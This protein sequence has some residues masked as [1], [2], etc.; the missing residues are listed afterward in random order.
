[1]KRAISLKY[2]PLSLIYFY[3]ILTLSIT[4]WGPIEYYNY[5][6]L[7]VIL[8]I[9][10]VLIAV[11]LG[12]FSSINYSLKLTRTRTED[13]VTAEKKNNKKLILIFIKISIIV[14]LILEVS[15]FIENIQ[16]LNV[17]GVKDIIDRIRNVGDTYREVL[18]LQRETTGT[19]TLVQFVT[20]FGITKQVAIVGTFFYRNELKSFKKITYLFLAIL[21]LDTLAFNGQQKLFA[22]LFIYFVSIMYIK[23][24]HLMKKIRK[25]I[26]VIVGVFIIIAFG[27]IQLSRAEAYGYSFTSFSNAFFSYDSDHIFFAFGDSIGGAVSALLYY[28]SGGYYGLSKSITIPFEWTYG[29]GNSIALSSYATQYL[30]TTFMGDYTYVARAEEFTGY[31]ALQ[32]WSTIFPWLASDLTFPGTIVLMFFISRLY[33]RTWLESIEK[34]NILSVLLFTR[35]NIL[36]AFLPAN[37][38]LM[39]TRESTIATIVLFVIWII[40]HSQT[41]YTIEKDIP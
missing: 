28:F 34:Y 15:L 24:I 39:Q 32:Y 17:G 10:L 12:Y 41:N 8:F 38:Q 1:M 13:N 9:L 19:N 3:I 4:F 20:L 6:Y 2:K 35:L 11:F 21:I 37:N 7:P 5:N 33:A 29:L 16:V 27:F 18:Q 31:P 14:A 25:G 22:D 36:W 26:I 30:G 40:F 23:Q